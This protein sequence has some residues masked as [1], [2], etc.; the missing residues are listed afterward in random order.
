[1]AV[2]SFRVENRAFLIFL[3][4]AFGIAVPC[5]VL[6]TRGAP[7][8]LQLVL[9]IAGSYAPALAAGVAIFIQ[10]DR[11]AWSDL[12]A[13][14]RRV[15]APVRLYLSAIILPAVVWLIALVFGILFDLS[16][17]TQWMTLLA[18][19]LIFVTNFGE[20]IGWRG[21]ALP[22]LMKR[23][24]PLIASLILGIIWGIF[25]MPLYLHEPMMA[26][27]EL[28]LIVA[29]SVILAWFFLSS[30][31]SLVLCAIFHAGLNTWGQAILPVQGGLAIFAGV[32]LLLWVVVGFLIARNG[33]VLIAEKNI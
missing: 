17:E 28:A 2:G 8:L 11:D 32:T 6:T 24:N 5:F 10:K 31:G 33:S 15:H 23:Y 18:F 21:F 19:P 14:I 26:L 12:I 29:V 7:A 27:T 16:R 22:F 3:L 13:R 1:M 20:E 30:R 9:L 25:H 4:L